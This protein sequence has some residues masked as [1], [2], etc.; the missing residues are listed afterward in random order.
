LLENAYPVG[1]YVLFIGF[2]GTG[3]TARDRSGN[4]VFVSHL[5]RFESCHVQV[6]AVQFVEVSYWS[7]VSLYKIPCSIGRNK[8]FV[9]GAIEKEIFGDVRRHGRRRNK[10]VVVL[11]LRVLQYQFQKYE[12]R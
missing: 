10:N 11:F 2:A 5:R 8:N 6:L 9:K 7:L 12:T 4:H 1:G 3:L